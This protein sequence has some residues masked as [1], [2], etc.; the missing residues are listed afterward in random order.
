MIAYVNLLKNS[1]T[2][3]SGAPFPT[4][5]NECFGVTSQLMHTTT[6]NVGDTSSCQTQRA[7]PILLI[8][9]FIVL[10][11]SSSGSHVHLSTASSLYQSTYSH[12]MNQ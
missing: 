3:V 7:T 1:T 2:A 9:H 12:L 11:T 6:T 4:Y 5:G 10:S 8:Q